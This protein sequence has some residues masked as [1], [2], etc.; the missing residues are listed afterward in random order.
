MVRNALAG[1]VLQ[2]SHLFTS[3]LPAVRDNKDITDLS[4]WNIFTHDYWGVNI[5]SERSHKG[6][7]LSV[8]VPESP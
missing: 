6:N 3:D 5:T 4:P 2:S 8:S 7:L 1:P